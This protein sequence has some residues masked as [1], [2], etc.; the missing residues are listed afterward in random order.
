MQIAG[1]E[2][3]TS[4]DAALAALGPGLW[5]CIAAASDNLSDIPAQT[6]RL[7]DDPADYDRVDGILFLST[8]VW[9]LRRQA[10]LKDTLA[11]S[12]R[13]LVIANANL[14]APRDHGFSLEPG[15]F[16]HLLADDGITGI[17]FFGKPFAEVYDMVQASLPGT[18]PDR[19]AMCG[20]TLHTDIL[21]AAALGWKTVLVAQ[22]GLFSGL[23]TTPFCQRSAVMPTW[24][25]QRI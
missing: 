13:P 6:L 19:I 21:G 1:D 17:R 22:D 5:G 10:I 20:D 15:H 2:I 23:D 7:E 18:A 4:R 12:P 11:R 25:V 14:A 16:G 24:R 3:V 9:T 8:E